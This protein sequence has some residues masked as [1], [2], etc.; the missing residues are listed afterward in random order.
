MQP[1]YEITTKLKRHE[2]YTTLCKELSVI[3]K[4][5]TKSPLSPEGLAD[6]LELIET[7]KIKYQCLIYP[8]NSKKSDRDIPYPM[9]IEEIQE[10]I[11]GSEE[12]KHPWLA[13]GQ[14]NIPESG[15]LYRTWDKASQCQILKVNLGF[16]SGG[17]YS[18]FR[19]KEG[20]KN[21]LQCHANWGNRRK[22]PF[23]STT[24]SIKVIAKYI[25]QF[26]RRQKAQVNTIMLTAINAKARQA[27]GWPVL[28]MLNELIHYG[29]KIPAKCDLATYV[30]EYLLPFRIR[31]EENIWTWYHTDT[32]EWLKDHKTDDMEVW[33]AKVVRPVYEEHERSRRAGATDDETKKNVEKLLLKL[34][35]AAVESHRKAVSQ[36]CLFR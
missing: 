31:P 5:S 25:K 28:N 29:A 10:R 9:T 15:I 13:S 36:G 8:G 30:S 6:G 24:P 1:N 23:I 18:D 33:E 21:H 17:S 19:S 22:T 27:A 16:L 4:K 32:L 2:R 34:M 3:L 26:E 7:L 20:R 11:Q 35:P 14:G 12:D